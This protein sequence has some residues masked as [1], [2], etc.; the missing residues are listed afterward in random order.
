[1]WIEAWAAVWVLLNLDNKCSH[2]QGS[3]VW[4]ILQFCWLSN[5]RTRTTFSKA[6]TLRCSFKRNILCSFD[7]SDILYWSNFGSVS[8]RLYQLFPCSCTGKLSGWDSCA[9][10]GLKSNAYD[11]R[12]ALET[13]RESISPFGRNHREALSA[14]LS[15]SGLENKG[16]ELM[17]SGVI[18]M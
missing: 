16:L 13:C 15:E 4:L 10:E 7:R 18:C 3:E 6:K 5:A 14:S 1:M 9:D 17:Y 11:S 2:W 8:M 12:A